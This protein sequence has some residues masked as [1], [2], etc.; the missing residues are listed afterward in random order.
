MPISTCLRP[1]AA[2]VQQQQH[3]V[4][5]WDAQPVNGWTH[6][7][8]QHL[9]PATNAFGNSVSSHITLLLAARGATSSEKAAQAQHNIASHTHTQLGTY[10]ATVAGSFVQSLSLHLARVL[11]SGVRLAQAVAC[12]ALAHS[13]FDSSRL[14]ASDL[15]S[16]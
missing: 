4:N 13:S 10:P 6:L 8:A 14:P 1:S 7:H 11:L 2:I 3:N 5:S 16:R 12:R 15:K 9:L